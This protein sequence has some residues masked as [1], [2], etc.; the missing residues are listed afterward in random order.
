MKLIILQG[1]PASG[2]STWAK[3]WMSEDPTSRVIINR[4]SI[5]RM[6]GKYWVPSR[7]KLVD[8]IEFNSVESALK[9]GF[10][11]CIDATNLNDKTICKFKDLCLTLQNDKNLSIEIVFNKILV[12]LEEALER[13]KNR[14]FPMGEKVIKEFYNKYKDKLK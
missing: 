10:D 6:L 7:E 4:D 8:D 13:D 11:V 12:S 2:K 5:R 14:K 9:R 3:K 1:I